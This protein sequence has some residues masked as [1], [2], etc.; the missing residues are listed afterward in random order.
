MQVLITQE[1]GAPAQLERQKDVE[2]RWKISGAHSHETPCIKTSQNNNLIV[3]RTS[4][5]FYF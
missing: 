4:L 2:K 5:F 1:E 3:L